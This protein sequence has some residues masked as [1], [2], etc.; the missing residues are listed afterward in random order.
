MPVTYAENYYSDGGWATLHKDP[1]NRRGTAVKVM[2]KRYNFWS[3]LEGAS[4]LTAPVTSPD[5]QS[6]Y[7]A[8]GLAPGN[9]NLYAYGIDGTLLWQSAPWSDSANGVDACAILSSPIVDQGGDIYI[10]DCNQLFAFTPDGQIKWVSQLPSPKE[11][12]WQPVAGFPVN[13]LTTAA[14]TRDG[15]ILGVTNHGDV[16]VVDRENGSI[17]NSPYRLPAVASPESTKHK[18]PESLLDYDLMDP[19]FKS[20]AWQV[21][22]AGNMRS[23]NTPAV[24]RNGRVFVVG[25]SDESGIGALYGLDIVRTAN[26][27]EIKLAFATKIGIGS[28]SSP[29]L[30]PTEHQVYVS[31]EDGEF[32]GI[33]TES[34]EIIWQTSSKAAAG[35]AAVGADGTV[36]ALQEFPAPAVI[37]FTPEGKVKWESNIDELASEYPRSILMGKAI[38]SANGN[39][40]ATSDAVLVPVMFG[41][42]IPFTQFSLPFKS[43]IVALDIETG[44]AQRELVTLVDDSSGIT[45]VLPDGT[46]VNSLGAVMT[47]AFKP[48]TGLANWL[49]PES[50]RLIAPVGGIQVSTPENH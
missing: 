17:V 10:N 37:A 29:A 13:A 50:L 40:A 18:L 47:S 28:G 11:G 16:I 6:L 2:E 39:P 31:D 34:G 19:R 25:S 42:S 1:G 8:T 49:M 22:F 24:A 33:S 32:Y 44:I 12:D 41:Y 35:A 20:W 3:S 26:S 48:L 30:S 15:N 9:S 36:Y 21:I 38:A 27:I 4:V 23:A 14:F 43:S 45:A 46:L 7:V 5:G